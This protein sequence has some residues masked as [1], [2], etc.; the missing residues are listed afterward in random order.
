MTFYRCLSRWI[1]CKQTFWQ[2]STRCIKQIFKYGSPSPCTVQQLLLESMFEYFRTR[3]RMEWQSFQLRSRLL[4]ER[5]THKRKRLMLVSCFSIRVRL[6]WLKS[7]RFMAHHS[8][9]FSWLAGTRRRR[10]GFLRSLNNE[11]KVLYQAS[12]PR[13]VCV[14]CGSF[15]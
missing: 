2:H 1:S 13:T 5:K 11:T 4:P 6:P 10:I 14:Q 8:W 3:T 12:Q 9:P 15:W 7:L